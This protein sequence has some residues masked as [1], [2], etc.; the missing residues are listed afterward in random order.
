MKI[1]LGL[2]K[3]RIEFYLPFITQYQKKKKTYFS[4][5]GFGL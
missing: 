1:S 4:I 3:K 2:V 5:L